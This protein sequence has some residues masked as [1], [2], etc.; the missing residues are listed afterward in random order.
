MATPALPMLHAGIC[1]EM[2]VQSFLGDC[3]GSHAAHFILFVE[4]FA[5]SL[6]AFVVFH[7][8]RRFR[9]CMDNK[10]ISCKKYVD[11]TWKMSG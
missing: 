1:L 7:A 9:C 11:N 6:V 4:D 10:R 3:C 8:V 5:H 2:F